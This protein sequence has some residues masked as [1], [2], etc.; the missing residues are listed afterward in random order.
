[1]TTPIESICIFGSAARGTADSMSDKDVLIVT[2]SPRRRRQ[3]VRKWVGDG[4]SVAAYSPSRIRAMA[5]KGSLF[6]QHLKREGIIVSDDRGWLAN[7]LNAAEP[8][9]SYETD[10]HSAVQMLKPLDRLRSG[11]WPQLMAADLGFVFIRNAGIYLLAE[12]GVY[13]F[14]YERIVD[15]LADIAGLTISQVKILHHLRALKVAYRLRDQTLID[16]GDRRALLETCAKVARTNVPE[17]IQEDAPIRLFPLRYATLRDLEARMVMQFDVGLM[18]H[19]GLTDDLSSL[20]KMVTTPREY[21]WAIREIDS[22][23]ITIA[24]Q[25]LAQRAASV[26]GLANIS[27]RTTVSAPGGQPLR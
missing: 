23:W 17:K 27:R 21:S 14:D 25:A 4:W 10:F 12:R 7:L 5:V 8:K 19:G 26:A 16:L 15:A 13:E 9:R 1:M 22:A 2:G 6:V 20:W 11:Y 18:D 3:L 24:N